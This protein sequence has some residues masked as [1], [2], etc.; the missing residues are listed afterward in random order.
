MFGNNSVESLASWNPAG[1]IEFQGLC[2]GPP[3]SGLS[4]CHYSRIL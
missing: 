4:Y 3:S 2:A 1:A